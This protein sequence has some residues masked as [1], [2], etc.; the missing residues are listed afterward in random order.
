MQG[1]N[2][3][4]WQ[5]YWSDERPKD[6]NYCRNRLVEHLSGQLPRSI[7]FELERH[8]RGQKRADIAAIRNTIG[9]PVEIKGQWRREVWDAACEQLDAKYARD[10]QAG[11]RGA[12]I[13]LWFGDVA[14]KNLPG[15]PQGLARPKTPG[16]LIL[17]HLTEVLATFDGESG[18][19]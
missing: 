9:L 8:M 18:V 10:W 15:H 12:Y 3:D 17:A 6:E 19:I 2:T 14:G 1:S 13:V 5:A 7:R 11:G 16:V 4:M